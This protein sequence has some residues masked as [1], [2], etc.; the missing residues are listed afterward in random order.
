MRWALVTGLTLLA[1]SAA[2]PVVFMLQAAFR[3]QEDWAQ[4]KI[5]MPTPLSLD[6]FSRAWVGANIGGYLVNSVIVT[7]GGVW[8]SMVVAAMA[9]YSFSKLVW[10]G[11]GRPSCS[12]WPGWP[13]PRCC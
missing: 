11:R 3:T 5:G 13:S 2:V 12:C 4:S 7:V 10:R 1:I 9:G 6:A 8:L